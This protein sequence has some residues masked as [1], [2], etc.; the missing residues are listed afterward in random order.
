MIKF[1]QSTEGFFWG[2]GVILASIVAALVIH[3]ILFKI[4]DHL[5]RRTAS[6]MDD[7]VLSYGKGPARLFLVVLALYYVS[8]ITGLPGNYLAFFKHSLDLL[9]ILSLV[10]FLINMT[11][12]FEKYVLG[13]FDISAKDNLRARA[14]TTQIRII[15]RVVVVV[16][17]ILGLGILL[18]SFGAVRQVGTSILAS[19]GIIGIIV[20]V[21]AQKTIANL[22]AGIQIAV[23]QPIRLDDVL[24]VE[25]EWGR[26]E[27]ITLTYVVVRIW[28]QRR[29]M[30]P[31][32]YF[33]ENPFQN[34][35]R[36][37]A[38]ILGT[39]Y[40]SVDY[41]MPVSSLRT[42]LERIV[43]ETDVWDGRVCA[44][45]VTDLK[46]QTMELRAL[47]SAADSSLAWELRCIVRERMIDFIRKNYPDSLP[48]CR[49][50]LKKP[51]GIVP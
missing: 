7:Y 14:I 13:K 48:L 41:T 34:W 25:N 3:F 31:I 35:T 37:N 26:V 11:S 44:L 16:I 17:S 22:L 10:W 6:V 49:A 38:E 5:S 23:T 47:V 1:V 12:V 43:R 40:F 51:E 36:T 46:E 28:D 27:E 39:V 4:G 21:A 20:G 33:L 50:T 8:P 45:Q 42:E 24:V 19:A 15:K 30:L 9:L 2:L 29:L 32:S 18:M